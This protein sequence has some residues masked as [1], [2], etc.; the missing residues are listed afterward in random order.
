M[1]V[2]TWGEGIQEDPH[3]GV[4]ADRHQ[5][6][7]DQGVGLDHQLEVGEEVEEPLPFL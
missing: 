2:G 6:E 1:A 5:E 3:W 4:E 7:E